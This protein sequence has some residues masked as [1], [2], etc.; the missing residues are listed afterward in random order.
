MSNSL[1]QYISLRGM[2]RGSFDS[3]QVA[4]KGIDDRGNE[5]LVVKTLEDAT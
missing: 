3:R 2:I 4:A 1:L 5:L